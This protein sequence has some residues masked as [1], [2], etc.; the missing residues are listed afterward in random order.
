MGWLGCYNSGFFQ[1]VINLPYL[2]K[3]GYRWA[4]YLKFGSEAIVLLWKRFIPSM[5]GIGIR[6]INL[7]ADSLMASFLPIGS[8]TA[9][10]F[11]NRLM[12]FPLGIFGISTGTAVYLF[13]PLCFYKQT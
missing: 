12:Q 6:E 9:L 10:N 5:I 1:T 13:I 8:I 7:I 11:G 4:I 2:K 3:I